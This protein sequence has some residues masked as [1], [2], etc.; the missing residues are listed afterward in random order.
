VPWWEKVVQSGK[1]VLK[2]PSEF[3]LMF[4][5]RFSHTIDAKGRVSIPSGFRLEL[6]T[7]SE[8]APIVTNGVTEAG[9][10]LW[11][12][13]Y[14]DWCEYESRLV[15]LA[16]DNLDVQSYVRFMVSGATEC[17]IDGQ[18][19]TLLPAFLREHA[20]LGRDVTI[21]GV[22]AR[23]EIWNKALFDEN[24]SRTQENFQRIASVVS[25]LER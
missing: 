17:P 12:Y 11:L 25:G 15:G 13:R 19:R 7:H 9:E 8:Q 2:P 5:G 20:Q 18:G 14:E 10:C 6:Q 1:H 24:Q 3:P 23:I 4:R 22:G 21:A 16:P